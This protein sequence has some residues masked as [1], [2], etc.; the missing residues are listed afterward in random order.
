MRPMIEHPT[1]TAIPIT[2]LVLRPGLSEELVLVLV[3]EEFAAVALA[4]DFVLV[5]VAL[6]AIL[7]EVEVEVEEEL[8]AIETVT[9]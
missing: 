4:V 1:D 8:L 5:F 6:V 2:P 3:G 9:P 7:L